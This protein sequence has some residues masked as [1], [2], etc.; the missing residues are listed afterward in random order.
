MLQPCPFCHHAVVPVHVHG[1][2]QC[3]VCK[4]NILPCCDGDN[5][6]TNLLLRKQEIKDDPA[7]ISSSHR[8][9]GRFEQ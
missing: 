5:C 2:Y 3:P 7:L 9:A 6:D 8:I 4:T 1:H